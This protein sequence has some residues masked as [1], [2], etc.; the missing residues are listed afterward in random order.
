MCGGATSV[1]ELLVQPLATPKVGSAKTDGECVATNLLLTARNGSRWTPH[2][3]RKTSVLVFQGDGRNR[4]SEL[5]DVG[6]DLSLH[7]HFINGVPRFSQ[8]HASRSLA[9]LHIPLFL[10]DVDNADIHSHDSPAGS[11][12]EK[13]TATLTFADTFLPIA[14]SHYF[15][16]S[17]LSVLY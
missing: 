11:F 1:V 2:P 7:P 15:S 13:W 14:Y 3:L 17:I 6:G 9:G 8:H 10:F 5:L 4:V 16:S 12:V